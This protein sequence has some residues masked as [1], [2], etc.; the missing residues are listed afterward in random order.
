VSY[1]GNFSAN[2]GCTQIVAATVAWSGNASVSVDCSAHGMR[3][4]PAAQ[5]VRMVE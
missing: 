2:D 5:P 1:N 3:S 4:L